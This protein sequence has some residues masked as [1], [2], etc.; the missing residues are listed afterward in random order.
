MR[1][2]RVILIVVAAILLVVGPVVLSLLLKGHTWLLSGNRGYLT[3]IFIGVI[4]NLS[5]FI[6][7]PAMFPVVVEIAQYNVLFWVSG[8]YALGSA[9]GESSAYVFGRVANYIP[10]VETSRWHR[11][12]EKRVRGRWKTAILIFLAIFPLPYDVGGLVAGNVGYSFPQF[13]IIAFLGK[14]VRYLYMIPFWA[15]VQRWLVGIPWF[16]QIA[17]FLPYFVVVALCLVLMLVNRRTIWAAVQ[18]LQ[19]AS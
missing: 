10:A 4:T 1:S 13:S 15:M 7:T 6:P 2:P 14:W 8:S 3:A 5:V 18:R 16:S 12:L 9:I 17:S 19:K 11:F